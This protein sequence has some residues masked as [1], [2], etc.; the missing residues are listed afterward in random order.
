MPFYNI[1]EQCTPFMASKRLSSEI[2]INI[3][4]SIPNPQMHTFFALHI[5]LCQRMFEF[6][7]LLNIFV[8][9]LVLLC[10]ERV[11]FPLNLANGTKWNKSQNARTFISISF[12]SSEKN[13]DAE[14]ALG[15][16]SLSQ[17]HRNQFWCG[18]IQTTVN[19]GKNVLFSVAMHLFWWF[20]MPIQSNVAHVSPS[21]RKSLKLVHFMNTR[22]KLHIWQK[23]SMAKQKS[24]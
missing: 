14:C 24:K 3:W 5:I 11:S 16:K 23:K 6:F 2:K 19:M 8:L 9:S 4:C 1:I 7:L 10:D 17:R 13:G 12:Y 21:K 22:N 15:F 20:F 18:K